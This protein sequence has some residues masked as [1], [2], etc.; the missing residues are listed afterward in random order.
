MKSAEL[1]FR[2]KGGARPS[3]EPG[4]EGGAS[5]LQVQRSLPHN[6]SKEGMKGLV[7]S[8]RVSELQ[9]GVGEMVSARSPTPRPPPNAPAAPPPFFV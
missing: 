8:P 9:D 6:C 2:G 7:S 4:Q 3:L 5:H 1:V